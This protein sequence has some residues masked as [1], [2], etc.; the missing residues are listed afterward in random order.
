MVNLSY[1]QQSASCNWLK[2][3]SVEEYSRSGRRRR[4]IQPSTLWPAGFWSDISSAASPSQRFPLHRPATGKLSEPGRCHQV[5]LTRKALH[6]LPYWAEFALSCWSRR[7]RHTLYGRTEVV[8]VVVVVCV[9]GG[10][11]SSSLCR[12]C[13]YL[14][15]SWHD[16]KLQRRNLM[17]ARLVGLLWSHLTGI[18]L[19]C[20]S[21]LIG[22]YI[23]FSSSLN[24]NRV[25][26]SKK[27]QITF[28]LHNTVQYSNLY[29]TT[30][31]WDHN[32]SV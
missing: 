13:W 14:D 29:L 31:F 5:G 6:R 9:G 8:V 12:T 30:C 18:G 25:C 16:Q 24:A 7:L 2:F 23:S 11:E 20:S 15:H 32:A 21:R 27:N 19:D 10:E 4:D 17:L 26:V 1:L 3:R 28:S 22:C